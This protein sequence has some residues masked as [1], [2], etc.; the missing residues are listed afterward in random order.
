MKSTLTC[1]LN[2][3]TMKASYTRI[4]RNTQKINDQI[5]KVICNPGMCTSYRRSRGVLDGENVW[6]NFNDAIEEA[7]E[8]LHAIEAYK[9]KK[10][11]EAS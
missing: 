9:V 4:T 2:T 8:V 6:S 10:I 7:T 3:S 11:I 5:L 1:E